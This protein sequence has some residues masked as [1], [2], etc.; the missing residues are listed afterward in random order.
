MRPTIP[1]IYR[2][3]ANQAMDVYANMTRSRS[4]IVDS[5]LPSVLRNY[6]YVLIISRLKQ[7]Y[8]RNTRVLSWSPMGAEFGNLGTHCS[9]MMIT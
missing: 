8:P 2:S 5:E 6:I 4:D 1:F 9:L 7:C 3:Y